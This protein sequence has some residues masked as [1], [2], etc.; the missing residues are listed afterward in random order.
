MS[1]LGS[2]VY[3]CHL[4]KA[5]WSLS[6]GLL[7]VIKGLR[8][9]LES[10]WFRVRSQFEVYGSVVVWFRVSGAGAWVQIKGCSMAWSSR[11]L[12]SAV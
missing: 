6:S 4:H 11:V 8:V 10:L 1:V 9:G 12:G 7:P 3:T 2:N 5:S